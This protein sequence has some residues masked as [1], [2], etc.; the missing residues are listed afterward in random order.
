[1]FQL[2]EE[3]Y[4][5]VTSLNVDDS[6]FTIIDDH[7]HGE[8][9]P[10]QAN[11]PDDQP[12]VDSTQK[13]VDF[14]E[15]EDSLL[16]NLRIYKRSLSSH[17]TSLFVFLISSRVIFPFQCRSRSRKQ[18]ARV[19]SGCNVAEL[20][21]MRGRVAAWRSP[22]PALQQ[23]ETMDRDRQYSTTAAASLSGEEPLNRSFREQ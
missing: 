4:G 2:K 15:I 12:H 23:R 3:T 18:R 13:A 10:T 21:V 19:A 8:T 22:S 14:I 20:A 16:Q 5:N 17:R 7:P 1:M 11:V 9:A 6:S